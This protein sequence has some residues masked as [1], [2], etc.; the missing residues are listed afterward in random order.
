MFE[1][2]TFGN[3][4]VYGTL[5]ALSLYC[6]QIL[7]LKK[8]ILRLKFQGHFSKRKINQGFILIAC[9]CYG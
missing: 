3:Y 5:V 4:A 8:L 7:Y 1:P 9:L 6:T 2:V